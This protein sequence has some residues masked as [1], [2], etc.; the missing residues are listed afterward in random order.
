MGLSIVRKQT[1]EKLVSESEAF[2]DMKLLSLLNV[3]ARS[4]YIDLLS[5]SKSQLRQDLFVLSEL[6]FRTGG[7]LLSLVRR[8]V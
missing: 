2:Y 3:E 8:M 4:K 1:L 6:G 7:F 5:S